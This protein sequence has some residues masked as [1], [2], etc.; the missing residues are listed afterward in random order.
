MA[1]NLWV[2]ESDEGNVAFVY[3]EDGLAAIT[4]HEVFMEI[5]TS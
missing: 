1:G 3:G 5:P 2:D 4:L